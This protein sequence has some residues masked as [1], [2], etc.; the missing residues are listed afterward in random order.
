MGPVTGHQTATWS[1]DPYWR[2]SCSCVVTMSPESS[3][4]TLL[5]AD[6]CAVACSAAGKIENVRQT[7][8]LVAGATVYPANASTMCRVR[9]LA[10]P[11]IMA[12]KTLS[13]FLVGWMVPFWAR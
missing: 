5:L 3:R 13:T 10:V 1:G 12:S 11:K 8:H 2:Q 6:V 4:C 7:Q 9:R